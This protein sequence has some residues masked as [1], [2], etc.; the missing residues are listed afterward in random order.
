MM[1]HEQYQAWKEASIGYWCHPHESYDASPVW[2]EDPKHEPYKNVLRKALPQSYKGDPGE[3]AAAVKA[4]YVVLNMFQAY[5]SGQ[6]NAEA[7]AKEAARRAE[8]YY[9]RA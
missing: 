3:A 7:A 9:K 1:E 8:R 6:M 5:V 2:T 4:D